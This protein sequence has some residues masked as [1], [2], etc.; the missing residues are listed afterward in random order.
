MMVDG[1]IV[2]VENSDR[3][4]RQ[5]RG[6]E[7]KIAVISRACREVAQPITFAIL[8]VVLVFIPL[9]TLQGVEGKMFRPLAYTV[10]LAMFGSLIYALIGAPVV[11]ALFMRLPKQTQ[12]RTARLRK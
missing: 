11:A 8:I 12:A 4:L 2:M 6:G 1:T 9:F 3:L 5:S 10:S 7:S